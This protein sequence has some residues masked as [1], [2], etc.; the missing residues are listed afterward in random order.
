MCHHFSFSLINPFILYVTDRDKLEIVE[1]ELS[2]LR[3][4][5]FGTEIVCPIFLPREL[6]D[7]ESQASITFAEGGFPDSID[8]RVGAFHVTAVAHHFVVFNAVVPG[9]LVFHPSD[10]R[11]CTL[12]VEIS[13]DSLYLIVNKKLGNTAPFTSTVPDAQL[14][15]SWRN[16]QETKGEV[17]PSTDGNL[18]S[19][20]VIPCLLTPRR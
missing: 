16:G 20:I 17:I 2:I 8:D 3:L 6:V 14:I 10:L 7:D 11:S 4:D 1:M 5:V 13:R 19:L 9:V 12:L 15:G 18:I